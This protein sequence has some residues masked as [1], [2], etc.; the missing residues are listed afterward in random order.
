MLTQF[1]SVWRWSALE[2]NQLLL[3]FPQRLPQAE[4]SRRVAGIAP[5]AE[6]LVAPFRARL[7]AMGPTGEPLTDDR[8]PVE[9]LTDRMI[10][11]AAL[12]GHGLDERALPTEP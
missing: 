8:A 7:S 2:F 12:S 5:A 9:W 6:P 4:L 3:A 11:R 10:F 1:P